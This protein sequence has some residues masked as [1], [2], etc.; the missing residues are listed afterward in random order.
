MTKDALKDAFTKMQTKFGPSNSARLRE[1]MV[2]RGQVIRASE[3][4]DDVSMQMRMNTRL[5]EIEKEIN[6]LS[7][8]HVFD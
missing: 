8:H 5:I 2:E 1:L 3:F 7:G 6:R 4:T